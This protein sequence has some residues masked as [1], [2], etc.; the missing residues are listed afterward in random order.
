MK[1]VL[2]AL[3]IVGLSSTAQAAQEL[4]PTKIQTAN[5]FYRCALSKDPSLTSLE[6]RNAEREGRDA[7]ARQISNPIGEA[8]LGF[9]SEGKQTLSLIQPLQLGGKRSARIQLANSENKSSI[10][11]D[12]LNSSATATAI[13]LNLV[14]HRHIE[15]KRALLAEMRSSLE[16]M[17]S[18]LK[19]KAIRT[20]EERTASTIFSMQKTV[21][22]T[23]MLSLTKELSEV[24][25]QLESSIGRKLGSAEILSSKEKKD[26]PAIS[27]DQMKS[28]F[29]SQ[30]AEASIEKSRAE[31]KVEES[32]AWPEIAIGPQAERHSDGETSWGAKLEFTVPIFNLNG[33][34][35]QRA[36]AQL[37]RAEALSA[38]TK[39]REQAAL[40]QL[41]EQYKILAEF[42]KKTPSQMAVVG[43]ISESLKL[44][45]R[46]LVQPSA[47]I[48]TYRSTL[49]ALEAIQQK[50][51]E[52]YEAYWIIHSQM[53]HFPREFQ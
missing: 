50:E 5:E 13:A 23:Q 10:I 43:S 38:L 35:K 27:P 11:E 51:L 45:S 12:Q 42:F 49:E 41:I 25:T 24:K 16:N 28:S 48:E 47:I 39:I 8:D 22:D 20:P 18:R 1:I 9:G 33:G 44:F 17:T 37:S 46:G 40:E 26:W 21:L 7:E 36:R 6:F 30:L 31:V 53:G 29:G 15:A 3:V 14:R 34:A 2:S 19:N 32:N 4:C 52:I